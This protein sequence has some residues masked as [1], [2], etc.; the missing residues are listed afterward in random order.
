MAVPPRGACGALPVVLVLFFLD[1]VTAQ[2]CDVSGVTQPT[3]GQFGSTCSGGAGTI[4]NNADCDLTCD[5][6][7]Y[8]TNQPRCNSGTLSSTTAT[9]TACTTQTGCGTDGTAC[10]TDQDQK[11]IC[12]AVANTQYYLSGTNNEIA[13]ACTDVANKASGATVT[14]TSGTTSRV[15]ACDTGFVK[16]GGELKDTCEDSTEHEHSGTMTAALTLSTGASTVDDYYNNWH[17]KTTTPADSGIVTDYVASTRVITVSLEGSGTTTS[18][19]VYVLTQY[20][21]GDHP[22]QTGQM[23]AEK[24]LAADSS[25]TDDFYNGWTIVTENPVDTGLVTDYDA[26]TKVITVT[27]AG[28][29][30]TS[31]STTYTISAYPTVVITA[32]DQASG[33]ISSGDYNDASTV[34]FTFTLSVTPAAALGSAFE[35]TDLV[36]T[37]C[38]GSSISGSGT[39]YTLACAASDGNAITAMVKANSFVDAD[40]NANVVSSTFTVNSDTTKPTVTITASDQDG[41]SISS[42]DANDASAITFTFTLSETP[43]SNLFAYT[44]GS[45]D[46]TMANCAG[47]NS[48]AVSGSGTVYTLVCDASNGNDITADVPADGFTDAAGNTNSAATQFSITSDTTAPTVT[49]T[50]TDGTLSGDGAG[51]DAIANNAYNDAS[52]ITFLFALSE[53]AGGGT[54][55][56]YSDITTSNCDGTSISG[57]GTAFKLVCGAADDSAVTA[58]FGTPYLYADQ[59]VTLGTSGFTDAAGNENTAAAVYT[60]N[61]DTT[62]P[63]VTITATDNAAATLTAGS[64]NDASTITFT[65]TLSETPVT[66]LFV[67]DGTTQDVTATNCGSSGNPAISGSGTAYTLECPASDGNAVTVTVAV[68]KFT[69]AAGNANAAAGSTAC[70]GT[71]CDLRTYASFI[72]N[73][74]TTAPTVTITATDQ[75]DATV[76]SGDKNDASVVTFTFTLS[77]APANEGDFAENDITTGHNCNYATETHGAQTASTWA[78][79]GTAFTL[80]CGANDG[81]TISMAV[82][83]SKFTDAAGNNNDATAAAFTVLS[84]TTAPF[85]TI[86][87]TDH[88]PAAITAGSENAATTMTFTFQLS[89]V[90]T[91]FADADVTKTNCDTPSTISGSGQTYTGTCASTTDN[92]RIVSMT[93]GAGTFTDAAGNS[94]AAPG[95]AACAATSCSLATYAAFTIDSD[96]VATTT[97]VAV[98]DSGGNSISSGGYSNSPKIKYTFTLDELATPTSSFAYADLTVAN[99]DNNLFEHQ[100]STKYTL[101]CDAKDGTEI[102]V[103][104]VQGT[105][106]AGWTDGAG[107]YNDPV[108]AVTVNSDITAPTVT[109]T[110]ADGAANALTNGAATSDATSPSAITFSFTVSELTA[111]FVEGDVTATGCNSAAWDATGAPAPAP[112]VYLLKCA[113]ADGTDIS[114]SLAEN[115][116]TDAAGN[117]NAAVSKFSVTSDTSAPTVTVTASDDGFATTLSTNAYSRKSVITWKFTLSEP[118]QPKADLIVGDLTNT[119]CINPLFSGTDKIWYLRCDANSAADGSATDITVGM[120]ATKFTDKAGTAN[121]AATDLVIKSDIVRP[122]VT[123]TAADGAANALTNGAATSDATSPSAIT[124]SF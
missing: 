54:A 103:A 39:S 38:D 64:Y 13:T 96:T 69:D 53:A 124:F 40:A 114:V 20:T 16:V 93:V 88:V 12:T 89:E 8:I 42:G 51:A 36:T 66:D 99:C 22:V 17:I 79:S 61:S 105:S 25:Y 74:D 27:L 45:G 26:G 102:S 77:E 6:G 75:D 41:V 29:S 62:K 2:T 80:T 46:I 120:G 116:L 67:H 122:T 106:S 59:L 19:T 34:T 85:V 110:A 92:G 18:S 71:S 30:T 50:A 113:A 37:N 48:Q 86:T 49:I 23:T 121:T 111:D 3:N 58:A 1:L 7:Y 68:N 87:A 104:V 55:F 119:N 109:I 78:G 10:S 123:I 5:T 32:Q 47:T 63:Y 94:N 76:T 11:L 24:T 100:G 82:A 108:S 112:Y 28:G 4:N 95:S 57:S 15:T 9:C 56:E 21:Q 117:G 107:N 72:V 91:N 98:T 65:F 115:V 43:V 35:F 90:S 60:I 84:D 97:T 83:G 81:N 31:A 101:E 44:S 33:S 118:P 73:S 70:T 14:C 52:S